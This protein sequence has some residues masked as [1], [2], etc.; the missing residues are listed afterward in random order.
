MGVYM[1]FRRILRIA[2]VL[3]SAAS[4]LALTAFA[5]ITVNAPVSG[6]PNL[7]VPVQLS[8]TVSSCAGNSTITAFGYSID[9]SP[10]I[11]WANENT[12]GTA[13]TNTI[14]TYDYRIVPGSHTIRFKARSDAGECPE[15]DSDITVSGYATKAI[16]NVNYLSAQNGSNGNAPDWDPGACPNTPPP[17]PAPDNVWFWTWDNGTAPCTLS[18]TNTYLA[19]SGSPNTIDGEARLYYVDWEDQNFGKSNVPEDPGERY[20]IDYDQSAS[21]PTTTTADYFVYDT[22]IYVTNAPDLFAVQMDTNWVNPSANVTIAGFLCVNN[23]TSDST[24]EFTTVNSGGSTI[25]NDPTQHQPGWT[26]AP[27]NPQQWTTT[28]TPDG[29]HHVQL[30]G[31][32]FECSSTDTTGTCVNYDS[33]TLDGNTNFLN[34][35]YGYSTFAGPW[36]PGDLVLNFEI[37]GVPN[38]GG[39]A[40]DTVY[41]DGMTM[42]HWTAPLT[43]TQ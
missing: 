15:A 6:A 2:A 28:S 8:A 9:S 42:I 35:W 21:D 23:G 32:R 16:E 27:C 36:N 26:L 3:G 31:H 22:Y 17:N 33:I 11:T 14:N 24:W 4:S 5:Q 30:T 37:Y 39:T 10:F 19:P 43:T 1:L 41:T 34:N 12:E 25:W 7:T 20:A 13:I 40:N 38:G 29:W 18:D